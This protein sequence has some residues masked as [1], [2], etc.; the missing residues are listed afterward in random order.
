MESRSK[1][2]TAFLF[3]PVI[4]CAFRVIQCTYFAKIVRF[5]LFLIY[6]DEKR[7]TSFLIH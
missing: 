1:S 6:L 4:D 5:R 2:V 3:F 7:T